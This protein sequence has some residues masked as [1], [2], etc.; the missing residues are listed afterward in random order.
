MIVDTLQSVGILLNSI[1][2][3][4]TMAWIKRHYDL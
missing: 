2:L 4:M 1:A 3:M